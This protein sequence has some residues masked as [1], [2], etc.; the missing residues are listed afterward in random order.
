MVLAT[1]NE[2]RGWLNMPPLPDLNN[3]VMLE[4]YIPASMI[5]N[6]KKLNQTTQTTEGEQNG[7]ADSNQ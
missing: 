5:G 3:L 1:G 2:V 4:N 7:E 6:Q